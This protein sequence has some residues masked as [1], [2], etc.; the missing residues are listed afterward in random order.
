[1]PISES[2]YR[3]VLVRPKYFKD[4]LRNWQ[5]FYLAM[6]KIAT[7]IGQHRSLMSLLAF[8][9]DCKVTSHSM[10][11]TINDYWTLEGR[12]CGWETLDRARRLTT[13]LLIMLLFNYMDR[14]ECG[15]ILQELLNHCTSSLMHI[16][17]RESPRSILMNPTM[18]IF[19]TFRLYSL[20]Y[21]M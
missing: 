10:T 15:A 16:R 11:R 18:N 19:P 12:H 4:R 21:L 14:S 2:R 9:K 13:T 8:W 5:I 3:I 7:T 20:L 1:M 17:E 6:I